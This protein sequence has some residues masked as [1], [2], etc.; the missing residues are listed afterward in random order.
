MGAERLT[1]GYG[2]GRERT[3]RRE[4]AAPFPRSAPAAIWLTTPAAERCRT[5]P[6]P[7]RRSLGS[8]APGQSAW[9][10]LFVVLDATSNV[11]PRI[12]ALKSWIGARTAE[13][14]L[15]DEKTAWSSWHSAPPAGL[16]PL[17][18]SLWQQSMAV[19]RMGQ[20]R[21]PGKGDGQILASLPPG[22]WNISWV[23]DMAYAV[24]ALVRSGHAAEAT[25]AIEFQLGADS[26]KYADT[27]ATVPDQHQLFKWRGG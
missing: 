27:S 5:T 25:R 13:Q 3:S 23:R 1:L 8:L 14:L 17:E 19:L 21:E 10:G 26:G 18:Q 7:E 11:A 20:V 6:Q 22:M 15:S 2:I 12:D 4:P 24:V 16:S 9:F